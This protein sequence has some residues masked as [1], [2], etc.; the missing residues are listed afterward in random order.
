[1]E[2]AATVVLLLKSL[3]GEVRTLSE[4]MGQPSRPTVHQRPGRRRA[5]APRPPGTLRPATLPAGLRWSDSNQH[6]KEV[7]CSSPVYTRGSPHA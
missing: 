3:I 7:T 2:L 6:G 5:S 1:M 4:R